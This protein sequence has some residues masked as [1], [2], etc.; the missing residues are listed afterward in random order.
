[1]TDVPPAPESPFKPAPPPPPSDRAPERPKAQPRK[2]KGTTTRRTGPSFESRVGAFLFQT[3]TVVQQIPFTQADALDSAELTLLTKGI[4]DECNRHPT[5]KRY[6]E[7][8]LDASSSGGLIL[9][10]VIIMS[11]RVVRHNLIPDGTLP[12]P[13]T[14][15]DGLLGGVVGMAV[16]ATDATDTMADMLGRQAQQPPAMMQA[17]PGGSNDVG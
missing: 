14:T 9:T 5:F 12:F 7:T 11:R 15:I 6:V 2:R 16:N 13:N 10:L 1:M 17:E 4:V 3:N 8:A